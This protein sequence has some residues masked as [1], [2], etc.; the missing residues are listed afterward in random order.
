MPLKSL[1]VFRKPR[2]LAMRSRNA[3][4][5]WSRGIELPPSARASLSCRLRSGRRGSITVGEDTLIAFKALIYTLDPLTGQVR[6]VRIGKHCFIGAGSIIT[7]GVSIGEGCI[8]GSGAVVLEDVPPRSIVVGNPG[9]ILR[10]DI[11]VGPFGRIPGADENTRR[12]YTEV[13]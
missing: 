1:N 10:R 2:E 3:W 12:L 11:T 8:V 4:L 13:D 5:R 7:P 6:P 9:R